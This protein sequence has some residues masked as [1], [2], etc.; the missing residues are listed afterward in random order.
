MVF[1]QNVF[2][3]KAHAND[4]VTDLSTPDVQGIY[5]TQLSLEFRYSF[6]QKETNWII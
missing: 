5:E 1:G 3:F 4:L 6:D 2:C